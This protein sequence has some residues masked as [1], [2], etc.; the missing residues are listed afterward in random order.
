LFHALLLEA[1]TIYTGRGG[2]STALRIKLTEVFYVPEV[3][4][5]FS[6]LY[7]Q[8]DASGAVDLGY[9]KGPS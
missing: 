4:Q 2:L 9:R 7:S 1:M 5:W 6:I 8:A 3:R